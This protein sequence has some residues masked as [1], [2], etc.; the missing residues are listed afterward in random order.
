MS[1]DSIQALLQAAIAQHQA[2]RP[3]QAEAL[4]RQVLAASPRQPDALHLLGVLAHERGEHDLALELI[5]QALAVA[6]G[7]A[8]CYSNLGNVLMALGRTDEAIDAY[9]QALALQPGLAQAC[10]NLGNAYRA[11]GQLDEARECYERALTLDPAFASAHN[12][13]GLVLAEQGRPEQAIASLER[14]LQLAADFPEAHNNMGM[15][16]ETLGEPERAVAHLE[17]ALALRPAYAEAWNNLGNARR[18]LGLL[19]PSVE[20]YRRAI[21]LR[22]GY[23]EAHNNLGQVLEAQGHIPEALTSYRQAVALQ[24]DFAEAH[25]NEALA[26]LRSGDFAQGWRLYEWRHQALRGAALV[27]R[28]AQP[29]WLGETPVEG[30]ALLLHYE[31]GLGDTLQML[32]Y[33]PLLARRGAHV[34]VEVPPA[35]EPVAR[36]LEGG[37]TVVAEGA[38][39]PAFEL[40][41]P[42]M[43]LPFALRTTLDEVPAEVPY[44]WA[45][46][47]VAAAWGERLGE[48]RRRRIGLAW[49]GSAGYTSAMR[50]RSLSL[51]E[52]LPLA[53]LDADLHS[54]QKEYRAGEQAR[55]VED[56]RIRDHSAQLLDF[57]E[58]AGLLAG[59]DLVISVD[60][61][62]A[63]LA[64]AMG[65]PVWLLLPFAADWR[66]MRERTDSPWYPTM[67]IFRQPAFGDW[68][69]VMRAVA[70]A[71]AAA[72]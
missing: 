44:L 28:F 61:A 2:G 20:S 57:G 34:I 70:A 43:S 58:T 46:A 40:Q 30:R 16:L 48:R 50:Q 42:L 31:Q 24:P 47:P 68:R 5:G 72:Q 25:L 1:S 29:T 54:I 53:G 22:P 56:G 35:V 23:V 51:Q 45:P 14:A 41:C 17:R 11:R 67:R 13:L 15:V 10:N 64:G 62:V 27:R 37:V 39:L 36:S 71:L 69:S 59:M 21:A 8:P 60:T 55:I 65:K 66:W 3:L 6:P 26:L 33:A 52:M 7:H 32:R 4:Y 63:H 12:N 38:A 9:R 18:A 19:E 49:S